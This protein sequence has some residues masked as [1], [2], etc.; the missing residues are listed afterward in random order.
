MQRDMMRLSVRMCLADMHEVCHVAM[1]MPATQTSLFSG[2]LASYAVDGS[3]NTDLLDNSCA[4]TDFETN[5][6]L[7]VDLG[8]PLTITG[9]HFTNRGD[10]S[11]AGM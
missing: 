4:H 6:W 10:D 5:P 9:V 1:N 3:R 11:A 2:F 7:M 8:I